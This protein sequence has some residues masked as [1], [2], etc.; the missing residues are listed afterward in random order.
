MINFLEKYHRIY[1][2]HIEEEYVKLYTYEAMIDKEIFE[3]YEIDGEDLEQILREQGTPAGYFPV[4]EGYELIPENILPEG[5]EYIKTLERKDLSGEE[6]NK[7]GLRLKELYEKGKNIENISIALEIN[8]VSVAAMRKELDLINVKDLK[9]EVE[10]LLTCLILEQLKRDKDG[11]IPISKETHEKPIVKRLIDDLERIF[12]EEKVDDVL[13]EMKSI[14][15]RDV[16]GWIS[17]E[18]FRKHMSQYKKRPI[19]W[20]VKS[21]GNSFECLLHYH[22]LDHDALQKLRYQY[23]SKAIEINNYRLHEQKEKLKT[24]TDKDA[25]NIYKI[26]DALE[27]VVED[28]KDLDRRLDTILKSG[29]D[30]I[31]DDG[32]MVN[33]APLQ[34]AGVL[35]LDV[36]NKSKMTKAFALGEEMRRE[37]AG[38]S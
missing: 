33:I 34:K 32:V 15:G 16:E 6:L 17:K 10:N 29:Y 35:S 9:H 28:L 3:L 8:P 18:F 11:I 20:H 36:L 19:V 23:L 21:Q 25:R 37:R 7:I 30:P 31:I 13:G 27:T 12:S 2:N 24:L 4:I 1:L 22:K 14:L 5:K 38:G 26:I